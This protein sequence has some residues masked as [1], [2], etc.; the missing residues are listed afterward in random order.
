MNETA[1][2]VHYQYLISLNNINT[3]IVNHQCDVEGSS[4]NAFTGKDGAI[5]NEIGRQ[6]SELIRLYP[7]YCDNYWKEVKLREAKSKT[8]VITN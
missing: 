6:I 1:F 8:N 2:Q 7:D 5:S 4:A 3:A